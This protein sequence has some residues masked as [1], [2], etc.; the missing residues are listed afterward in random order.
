MSDA[1][2]VAGRATQR[3]ASITEF[4]I[5]LV[6]FT[7]VFIGLPVIA[8]YLDVKQKTIEASRYAAC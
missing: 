2:S 5:T 4:M 6:F 8:K 3:G 1:I 7:P